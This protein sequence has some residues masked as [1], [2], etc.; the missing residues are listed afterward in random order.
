[1]L[2]IT[3]ASRSPR[4]RELLAMLVPNDAIVVRPPS[5]AEEDPL[6]HLAG[7]ADLAARLAAIVTKKADLVA[8]ATSPARL[9]AADTTVIAGDG[10]DSLGQPA[11][12]AEAA[13]FLKRLSGRPHRVITAVE[14]REG[15]RTHR[16]LVTTTVRFRELSDSMI[17]W[18]VGTGEPLGK[19]GGYAIQG[20]GSVLV[21]AVEGSLSNVI[22]LPLEWLRDR[23]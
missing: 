11:D 23:V 19:A 1:M 13:A 5:D 20:A 18:Y 17:D 2:P 4:R 10:L 9:L 16:G 21:A 22:G 3:L 12:D 6:D 15:G 8:A 7:E 14:L